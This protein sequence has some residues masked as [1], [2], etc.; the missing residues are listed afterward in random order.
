MI[1]RIYKN[2]NYWISINHIERIKTYGFFSHLRYVFNFNICRIV[3]NLQ[4]DLTKLPPLKFPIGYSVR[5]MN[6]KNPE[7]ITE[8]IRIVN[9]AYPDA[10]ESENSFQRHLCNHSFLKV[11]KI[12]FLNMNGKPIGT[13]TTGRYI[14]NPSIG[15]DARIAVLPSEQGKGLGLFII[16]YAFHYLRDLGI[17]N[18]ESVITL[19]RIQSILLH[20]KCGFHPQ[21][22]RDK[23]HFDMQKRMWPVRWIAYS[24]LIKVMKINYYYKDKK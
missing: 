5:E 1:S 23:I 15:G 9:E 18:A 22:D 6:T 17:D 3:V 12:F 13:I 16:N 7:D 8:W 2:L 21:F 11:E 20:L 14:K 4:A 19:K 10:V 24:K